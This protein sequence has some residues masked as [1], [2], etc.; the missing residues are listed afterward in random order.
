M[1]TASL[2]DRGM[3]PEAARALAEECFGDSRALLRSGVRDLSSAR[4]REN[5]RSRREWMGHDLRDGARRLA[6]HPGFTLLA[7]GTLALGLSTSTAVFTYVN[8]YVQ[9][10]PGAD[11]EGVYQL[12]QS[13]DQVAFGPI[14]YP[15]FR[16]LA[17]GSGGRFE[18]AGVG[19]AQFAASARHE[20]MTEVVFGQ[21]VTGNFFPMLEVE[22]SLGRGLTPDDDRT[23]S[24]PAVVISHEY[25]ARRYASDPGALGRTLFLNNNPYTI[26]GVA[27]PSFL[28]TVSAFRP[29]V[30][31]PLEQYKMVYWARS[32]IEMDREGWVISP[33]L[34]LGPGIGEEAATQVIETFTASLDEEAPLAERSRKFFVAPATWIR[35]QVRQAELPTTR[36]MLVAAAGLLLLACANVANLV[37]SAGTRRGQE[38]ALRSA[39]GASRFRLVR[40]LLAES[41]LLSLL[42][43]ALSLL[44]AGPAA[45][46]LSSYFARPSVWGMDVPREITLD[47][48]VLAFGFVVAVVSGIITGILPALRA[49]GRNPAA[50]LKGGGRWSSGDGSR[51]PGRAWGARDLLVSVQIGLSMV[52]LFL[53]ALVLKTLNTARH[54]DPGFDTERTLASYVSTSSMG[55]PVADREAFFRDLVVRFEEMP[56]VQAATVAEQAP[57]SGH[58]EADLRPTGSE[59]P[60]RATVARVVPGY[61]E[62]MGMEIVEGRSLLPEDTVDAAGVVVVNEFL[63]ERLMGGES[64]LGWGLTL[65]GDAGAETREYEIV[66]VVRNARQTRFPDEPGPVA[67]FS[68]PQGYYRPGNAFLVKVTGDPALA[69]RR[70]EEELRAVDSRIAIVNILPYAEVVEGFLYSRRMNAELFSAIAVLALILVGAGVFGVMSLLV[71]GR[72]REIGIRLAIGAKRLDI[73]RTVM[74]RVA[75]TVLLGMALGAGSAALAR[76]MVE[77]LL[78]GVQP[79][80]PLSL[81]L[82]L[83]VL[84]ATVA[85]AAALP[86]H[87]AWRVDP[88]ASLR[89]E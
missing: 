59:E 67:Y 78:W 12:F 6:R 43:G 46:R 84:C 28:G 72:R 34:R 48:R 86:L 54:V 73:A 50:Q 42:A 83:A 32:N 8:A 2:I 89:A 9:P 68:L 53:A 58:P 33:F 19:D 29:H 88:A 5:R 66:G 27:A 77:A 13:S 49:S 16:D 63:A 25:W 36:I 60:V 71:A 21:A 35:P 45:N 64:P 61:F 80:D 4:R 1:K 3:E 82:G 41:I 55:T 11:T 57:L 85:L 10:F 51:A 20:R 37:L 47:L 76:R 14:S 74:S 70:M 40:Q 39:M 79:T 62:V 26:V 7:A 56:W 15:D 24:E 52:L 87:R 38:M 75:V 69:V 18:V 81:G 22:L 23:G 30:W 44:A 17:G 31:M 65:P